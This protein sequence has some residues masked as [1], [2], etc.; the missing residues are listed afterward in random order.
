ME[1]GPVCGEVGMIIKTEF[2]V[3]LFIVLT[4]LLILAGLGYMAYKKGFFQAEE[5]LTLSSRTGDGL[6][7]GMPLNFSGFK[8]G[9]VYE[10]ELSEQGI[11]L[12]KIR[13]PSQHFKWLR[14]D[15][16][17]I[18][19]R[20]LIGS[21]KLVVV[22]TNMNSA[23]LSS[24]TIPSITEVNDINETIKKFEP[25]IAKVTLIVDHVEKLTGSLKT[26]EPVMEKLD[27]IMDHVEKL[28]GSLAGKKS[29]IEMAVGDQESIDALYGALKNAKSITQQADGLLKKTDEELYGPAGVK[30]AVVKVLQEL[31]IDLQ[32][33]GK[34]LDNTTKISADAADSTKDLKL[35]RGEIDETVN[36]VNNLVDDLNKLIPFKKEPTIRLP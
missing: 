26:F 31:V 15:S 30:P 7:V 23:L 13:V 27:L 2:K 28:T 34:T 35:L 12:V 9:K 17:F 8:I 1:P 29:L 19:E 3:G 18:L 25:V 32:K 22:T 6:T 21:T 11:V 10:L 4:V 20:P 5:T 36:S 33:L 24:K 16:I 14:S